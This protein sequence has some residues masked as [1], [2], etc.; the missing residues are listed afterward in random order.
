M[1]LPLVT[2]FKMLVEFNAQAVIGCK[3]SEIQIVIW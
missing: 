1:S 2:K 3:P